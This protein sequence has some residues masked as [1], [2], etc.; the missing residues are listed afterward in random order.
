MTLRFQMGREDVL[1]FSRA[2]HAA[3]PTYRRAK[4]RARLMLPIMMLIL[5]TLTTNHSGFKVS[6]TVI[7]L[8]MG[9]LWFILYPVLFNRNVEKYCEKTIDE[10][11]HSKNFGLCELTLS[12][13]GL[14]DRSPNGEST[15][16]WSAV[17]RVTLTDQYLF[18]F[19]NGPMGYPIPIADVGIEAA[20][21]ALEYVNSHAGSHVSVIK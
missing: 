12:E 8:G 15:F 13:S 9:I 14:H 21:A 3:S 5:L 17:D 11:S 16:Y 7:F 10:G 20:R 2:Y 4:T 18:I 1:A 19:L 6:N